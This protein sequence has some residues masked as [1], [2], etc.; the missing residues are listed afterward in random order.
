MQE[1]GENIS[2]EIPLDSSA[3]LSTPT[4]L[5]F[6]LGRFSGFGRREVD[7]PSLS[8]A[9]SLPLSLS[10]SRFLSLSIFAFPRSLFLLLFQLLWMK[11]DLNRSF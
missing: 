5:L 3:P 1:E 11:S 8:L 10:L 6:F 7:E 9:L 2:S 4:L